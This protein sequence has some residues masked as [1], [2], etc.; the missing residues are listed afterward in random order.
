MIS[1]QPGELPWANSC[2]SFHP[3]V[4]DFH[5]AVK[6]FKKTTKHCTLE[7][8]KKDMKSRSDKLLSR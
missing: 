7:D 3:A 4:K 8:Q 5:G 1:A 2:Y 6:I